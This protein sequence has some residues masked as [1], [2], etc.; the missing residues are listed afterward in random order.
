MSK[1]TKLEEELVQ[2]GDVA[3]CQARDS[4]LTE[5]EALIRAFAAMMV[6]KTPTRKKKEPT[7]KL[8]IAPQKFHAELERMLGPVPYSNGHQFGWLGRK[9]RECSVTANELLA[10]T[11]YIADECYPWYAENGHAFTMT[12]ILKNFNRW[13]EQFRAAPTQKRPNKERINVK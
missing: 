7:A 10:F 5:G 4:E 12:T 3:Y 11:G 13:L 6:Y 9:F 8:P 2:L 1:Q